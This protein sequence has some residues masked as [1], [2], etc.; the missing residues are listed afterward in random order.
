MTGE[1]TR[2]HVGENHSIYSFYVG[3]SEDLC[4]KIYLITVFLRGEVQEA[5]R[6]ADLRRI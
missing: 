5:G 2:F 3:D 1:G 4:R 6:T